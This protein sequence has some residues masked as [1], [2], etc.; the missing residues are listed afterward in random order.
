MKISTFKLSCTVFVAMVLFFTSEA[1]AIGLGLYGSAGSGSADVKI[2][3]SGCDTFKN[4]AKH[5]GFGFIL[6][7]T[8]AQDALYTYRLNISYEQLMFQ[9][10]LDSTD[11]V[12]LDSLVIDNDFGFGVVRK[13]KVRL[14]LGPELRVSYSSGKVKDTN[15]DI[16]LG[17]FG[18]GPVI[19]VNINLGNVVTLGIK[20][21]YLMT[22]YTGE[23][24]CSGCSTHTVNISEGLPFINF[25]LIF[26][27]R[28]TYTNDSIKNPVPLLNK[29]NQ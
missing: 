22:W 1:W 26:R 10:K 28:D 29:T 8:V 19:G 21:G 23:R 14:W 9:N 5:I 2:N 4:D 27:I 18:V 13:K 7:T 20:S 16:D 25:A 15:I 3:C 12:E 6:D 17:G 11:E 24:S